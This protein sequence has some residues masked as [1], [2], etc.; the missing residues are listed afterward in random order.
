M[1]S[2]V[3]VRKVD[4]PPVVFNSYRQLPDAKVHTP[5]PPNACL[6][7]SCPTGPQASLRSHGKSFLKAGSGHTDNVCT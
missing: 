5:S 3:Q 4:Q 2:T 6:L 1:C 7:K